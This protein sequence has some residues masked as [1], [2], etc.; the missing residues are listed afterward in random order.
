MQLSITRTECFGRRTR[1]RDQV[2]L[3]DRG[4]LLSLPLTA[5]H[6]QI[7]PATIVCALTS[8]VLIQEMAQVGLVLF[9][10]KPGAQR[11]SFRGG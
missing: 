3:E 5:S 10:R 6:W 2:L 4:K 11:L 8:S 1:G 9:V 7:E